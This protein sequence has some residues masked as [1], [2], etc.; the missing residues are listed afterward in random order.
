MNMEKVNTGA[1]VTLTIALL[2]S[3]GIQVLPDD[4]HYC[5]SP[6]MTKHCERLSS[7]GRTC[8]PSLYTRSGSKRCSVPWQE[9]VREDV[10]GQ[11]GP[12]Q[13]L[14]SPEGCERIDKNEGAVG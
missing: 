4:T 11:S 10:V 6:E 14:C 8:Y 12:V 9:I 13:Y 7:T 5:P 2:L 1:I 3:W